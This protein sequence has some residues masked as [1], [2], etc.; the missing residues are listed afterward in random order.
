MAALFASAFVLGLS[1]AMMPGSLLTYTVRASLAS[2]PRAGFVITAGHALLELVL[3]LLLFLG[4]D[5]V[6]S[7]QA[8][9][10]AV[11]LV[12]GVLLMLMGG[13][14]VRGALSGGLRVEA[15]PDGKNSRGMFFS[16]ILISAA[17]PYFLMWWAVIGLGFLMNAYYDMGRYGVA[18][19][20]LGHITADFGWYGLVSV[21]VGTTGRFLRDRPY[22]LMIGVLGCVLILFGG[23]FLI[24]AAGNVFGIMKNFWR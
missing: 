2:G 15:S 18:V 19:F 5:A 8:V 1:G 6:L 3:V 13:D 20:Y 12:G 9:Q 10:T 14:M 24:P 16:G 7:S 21:L 11:G 17:N 23:G 22:R 4:L